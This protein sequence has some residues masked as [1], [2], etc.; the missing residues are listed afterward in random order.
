MPFQASKCCTATSFP[1]VKH[2]SW[3]I[4][5]QGNL[6]FVLLGMEEYIIYRVRRVLCVPITNFSA[7]SVSKVHFLLLRR[8]KM[9]STT[10][11]QAHGM[12]VS[13]F[14]RDEKKTCKGMQKKIL[15]R[16]WPP[17]LPPSSL[18]PYLLSL[19]P[20]LPVQLT[21]TPTEDMPAAIPQGKNFH[22]VAEHIEAKA[23]D[24]NVVTKVLWREKRS[25]AAFEGHVAGPPAHS[26][27]AALT[28]LRDKA[29]EMARAAK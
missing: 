11:S 22:I 9:L 12:N 18:V 27:L 1:A 6:K 19:P 5:K 15:R 8:V 24:P 17:F 14:L 21:K 16:S 13:T 10:K 7:N 29:H 28:A 2:I 20:L 4:L 3:E 23:G 26:L 25:G